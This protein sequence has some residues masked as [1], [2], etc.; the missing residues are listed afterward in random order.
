[1]QINI[2]IPPAVLTFFNEED[3]TKAELMAKLI[4]GKLLDEEFCMLI[5]NIITLAKDAVVRDIGVLQE[6]VV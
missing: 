5:N 2:N 3:I 4:E 6:I 1:M